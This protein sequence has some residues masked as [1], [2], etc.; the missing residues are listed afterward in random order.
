MASR[1]RIALAGVL[2]LATSG[3]IALVSAGP[4]RADVTI[5]EK[6]G[7][8]R[9]QGGQYIV[10]N[11][12][13]GA[14]TAQCILAT[15]TGFRITS[16]NHNNATNGAP[17]AYPSIY[18]G[19]HYTNCSTG[20]LPIQL[21]QLSSANSSISYSYGGG[22]FNASYDIWLDPTRRTDGQ[23]AA[24][25]MIWFNRQGSVQPVGSP[26]GTVTIEGRQW[27]VWY[28]NIGWHVISYVSP[29]VISSWNFSVRAFINDVQSRGYINSSWWLTSVQAGFEPWIG[30]TGH[31][32]NSFSFTANGA[33]PPPPPP[34]TTAPPPPPPPPTTT[35]PPP[36]PGGCR[37]RYALESS[38]NN[39]FVANVTVTNNGSS[40]INGWTLGW[41]FPGDQRVVNAWN[42]VVA[43]SGGAAHTARN[44]DYN[45][46][47]NPGGSATFGFQGAFTSSNATP[48]AFTLN[49]TACGNG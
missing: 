47:I 24:E 29:S 12:V 5:C 30:G 43:P 2:V 10:Q 7:S 3:V 41:T 34:T 22:T 26:V 16:A 44:V 8:T 48:T 21:T 17:A 42:A 20:P 35:A 11:N 37:V 39:G 15:E 23:N 45:R 32:V 18:S 14:N 6:F 27:Q 28:G 40:A 36:P 49:G 33:P 46:T 1:L 19:C 4:A 25:I 31:A 38:W 9:I 13:W